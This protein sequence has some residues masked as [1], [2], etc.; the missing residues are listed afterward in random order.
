MPLQMQPPAASPP[1]NKEI[2]TTGDGRDITRE[3]QGALFEPQDKVLKSKGG[4]YAIYEDLL[5][6]DQVH[7]CFQQR[8]LAVVSREWEVQPGDAENPTAVAAADWV[9]STLERIGWDNICDK[10]LFGIFYGYAIAECLYVP[11]EKA[12][13]VVR[14]GVVLTVGDGLPVIQEEA[15]RELE[16][17][18]EEEGVRELDTLALLHVLP[19][20]DCEALPEREGV[21]V[22]ET[23]ALLHVLPERD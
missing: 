20:R 17:Q 5:R 7:S 21:A 3:L 15:L 9:R 10:M 8:R 6:D 22:L 16:M 11:G 18:A 4:D 23:L 2:A 14:E 12:V 19:V 13:E 1:L